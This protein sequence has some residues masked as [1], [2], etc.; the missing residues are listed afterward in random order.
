MISNIN[1]IPFPGRAG[2]LQQQG[3]VLSLVAELGDNYETYHRAL[4]DAVADAPE[5][6]PEQIDDPAEFAAAVGRRYQLIQ[7]E[8]LLRACRAVRR[9]DAAG[10]SEALIADTSPLIDGQGRLAAVS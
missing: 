4:A 1:E 8:A 10:I 9:G 7:A 5:P 2:E 3:E 6:D